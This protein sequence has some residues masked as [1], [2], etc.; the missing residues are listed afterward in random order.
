MIAKRGADATEALLRSW[1]DNDPQIINSDGEL[2]AR[3]RRGRLRRRPGQPLL[4][5]PGARGGP[6][7]PRRACLARPGRRRRPRQRVGR[8]A[9]SRGSDAVPTAVALMEYLTSPPAQEEIVA[10][11]EFAANPA[12]A[13]ARAHRELGGREDR[14]DRRSS[15]AGP[16]LDQAV[17]MMLEVGWN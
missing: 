1:M 12:V 5:R 11:S 8:R 13:A 14:P 10:G 15:E 3:H 7:L 16:L 2:L 17:A 9:W 4:P 6:E